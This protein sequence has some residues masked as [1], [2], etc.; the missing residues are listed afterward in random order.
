MRDLPSGARVDNTT[1]PA[2]GDLPPSE[3]TASGASRTQWPGNRRHR[4]CFARSI[5]RPAKGIATVLP[6]TMVS[7]VSSKAQ[8]S[9]ARVHRDRPRSLYENIEI[10]ARDTAVRICELGQQIVPIDW[11][12]PARRLHRANFIR[13]VFP[14]CATN[15]TNFWHVPLDYDTIRSGT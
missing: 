6:T 1:K 5:S 11:N 13:S 9:L 15:R 4:D 2:A 14:K 3:R 12:M 8:H 7:I 10:K